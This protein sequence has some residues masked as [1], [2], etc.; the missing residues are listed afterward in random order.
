MELLCWG[1]HCAQPMEIPLQDDSDRIHF[2]FDCLMQGRAECEF[3]Q[4]GTAHAHRIAQSSGDISFGRV[5]P[6]KM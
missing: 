3:M 5:R 2:S 6:A 1:G 4:D